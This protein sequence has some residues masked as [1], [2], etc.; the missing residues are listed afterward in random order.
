MNYE[1][2]EKARI[3]AMN[4]REISQLQADNRKYIRALREI[5]MVTISNYA[6]YHD[7]VIDMK[8]MA[9]EAVGDYEIE[10]IKL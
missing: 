2:Y 7:M 3:V 1:D 5:D 6:S 4:D 9:C 8:R 10:T